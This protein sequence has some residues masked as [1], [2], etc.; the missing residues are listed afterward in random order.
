[1]ITPLFECQQDDKNVTVLVRAPHSRPRDIDISVIDKELHFHCRPYL[2]HLRFPHALTLDPEHNPASY[3]I[4]TG[5]AK[6]PLLKTVQGQYFERLDML[7]TLLVTRKRASLKDGNIVNPS[8]NIEV[9]SSTTSESIS[10]ESEQRAPLVPSARPA[11]VPAIRADSVLL[12]DAARAFR[13]KAVEVGGVQVAMQQLSFSRQSR[14]GFGGRY[15][16]FFD[17]R[18]EDVSELV[19]LP[20]P[21]N[22]PAW[23]RAELRRE[24]EDNKF[25]AEHYA[26]DFMLTHEFEYI[27]DF[28]PVFD[29]EHSPLSD[30]AKD[31]MLK[32]PKRENLPDV[33]AGACADLAGLLYASCYDL[34]TTSGERS[35]ESPW[36]VS[37]LCASFS[38]LE[39]MSSARDA[40]FAAYRRVLVYP[41]YRTTRLA[42]LVLEDTKRLMNYPS[43]DALRSRLLRVLLGL[44]ELFEQDKLLRVFSDLFLTDYCVWIQSV[45]DGVLEKLAADIRAIT[46]RRSSLG[47]DL[48]GL[49]RAAQGIDVHESSVVQ[50]VVDLAREQV[51]AELVQHRDVV[52]T[53]SGQPGL[54]MTAIRTHVIAESSS[55][56]ESSSGESSSEYSSASDGDKEESTALRIACLN[57]RE[58]QANGT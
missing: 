43:V 46:I 36:T 21:D 53:A 55:S 39:H 54:E 19:E 13:E 37:R 41:L 35:V 49:E 12:L 7:S 51:D 57:A 47:W 14:Y 27:M 52:I 38:F 10:N 22:T 58:T 2:L 28:S 25:D 23:R 5:I 40:V 18:A 44:R 32:L 20:D 15:E 45:D 42:A 1:M 11:L 17:A 16:A 4:T 30:T 24:K 8:P 34:R 50:P 48:D 33:D 3:D 9:L 26:A 6:I 56:E 31:A 29:L